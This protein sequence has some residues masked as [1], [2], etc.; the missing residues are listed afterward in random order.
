MSNTNLAGQEIFCGL[1][2]VCIMTMK[3][4]KLSVRYNIHPVIQ[5]NGTHSYE[6]EYK[7]TED[8]CPRCHKRL[9]SEDSE[10][11]YYVGPT[12]YCPACCWVG[13][14][15]NSHTADPAGTDSNDQI[16]RAIRHEIAKA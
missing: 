16:I 14:I 3:R 10:G 13:Y 2:T 9:W 7:E 6:H 15:I 11:D 1:S 12:F 4:I 5:P 8:F